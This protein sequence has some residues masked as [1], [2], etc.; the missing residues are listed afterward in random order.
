V[1]KLIGV[2]VSASDLDWLTL[3]PSMLV[4]RARTG[5]VSLGAAQPHE[6]SRD[7]VAATLAELLA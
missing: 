3:R 5:R 1:K 2:T 6:V 4:D 7:D